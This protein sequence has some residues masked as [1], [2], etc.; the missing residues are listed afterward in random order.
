MAQIKTF[1]RKYDPVIISANALSGFESS[2]FAGAAIGQFYAMI[3]TNR[4]SQA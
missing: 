1:D 2:D 3:Y 4:T